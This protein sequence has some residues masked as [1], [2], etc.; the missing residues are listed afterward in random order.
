M[1]A[2]VSSLLTRL[3]YRLNDPNSSYWTQSERIEYLDEAQKYIT[4]YWKWPW[5]LK[6]DALDLE[7][8]VQAYNTFS[9]MMGEDIHSLYWSST[10]HGVVNQLLSPE[11][12]Q[13]YQVRTSGGTPT[14]GQPSSYHIAY[15][16]SGT[17]QFILDVPPDF[18][19][20]DALTCRYFRLANT[21]SATTD[22]STCPDEMT[23]S[24]IDYAY[25]K[26]KE[27]EQELETANNAF[28]ML[29]ARLLKQKQT[30]AMGNEENLLGMRTPV[31]GLD[32]LTY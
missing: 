26:C 24:L 1:A 31:Y 27:K 17:E 21:L 16:A 2:L 25:A 3:N 8:G 6:V 19:Q 10:T 20:A 7:E 4:N 15:N 18:T 29:E 13:T 12:L 11:T 23:M 28:A 5:R 22:S 30:Y 32:E 14:N 9:D